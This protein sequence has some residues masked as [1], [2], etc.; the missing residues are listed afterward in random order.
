[1]LRRK[2]RV[3][4]ECYTRDQEEARR[5]SAPSEVRLA[6]ET[7][8]QCTVTSSPCAEDNYNLVIDAFS[9]LRYKVL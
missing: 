1:M 8:L 6:R 9:V 5:K 3:S 4:R 7:L 2:E